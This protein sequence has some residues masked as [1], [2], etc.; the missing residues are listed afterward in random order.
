MTQRKAELMND[1]GGLYILANPYR[2]TGAANGLIWS[3]LETFQP[4]LPT[5]YVRMH[6]LNPSVFGQQIIDIGGHPMII[7]G[8]FVT[9]H[10]NLKRLDLIQN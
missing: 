8:A 10:M 6:E 9:S 3:Q 7:D 1:N 2:A 5:F 4:P